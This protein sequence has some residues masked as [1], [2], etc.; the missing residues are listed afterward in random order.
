[1]RNLQ[2][3]YYG[4]ELPEDITSIVSIDDIVYASCGQNIYVMKGKE[5]LS[6]LTEH[7]EDISHMMVIGRLLL[8][9]G[10]TNFIVWNEN[11][12]IN[13]WNFN[14]SITCVLHPHTYLDKILIG[15][16]KG[17]L[18][19]M[20]IRVGKIIYKFGNFSSSISCME[21]SSALDVI[22]IGLSNGK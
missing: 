17:D 12:K 19:L 22:G 10:E 20:N 7:H 4:P 5:I 13:Q 15:T 9:F 3:L 21:N 1:L 16:Q 6:I 18:F 2:A 14:E 8:S 11:E